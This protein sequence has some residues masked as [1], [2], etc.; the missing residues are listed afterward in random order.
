MLYTQ[1]FSA[2]KY[3]PWPQWIEK[4]DVIDKVGVQHLILDQIKACGEI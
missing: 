4:L 3:V 2:V 1:K